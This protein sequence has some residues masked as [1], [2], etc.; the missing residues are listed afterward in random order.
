MTEQGKE[1][2]L[3]E[4]LMEAKESAGLKRSDGKKYKE[5]YCAISQAKWDKL[6]PTRAAK[7]LEAM[8]PG[9]YE[10]VPVRVRRKT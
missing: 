7:L 4:A 8:A 6:G 1:M 9:K 5:V 3:L 2:T 10:I